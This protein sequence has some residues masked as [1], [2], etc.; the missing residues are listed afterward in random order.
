MGAPQSGDPNAPCFLRA[1]PNTH[2]LPS[3][4]LLA[5][6]DGPALGSS[7]HG[8]QGPYSAE[9]EELFVPCQCAAG[10]E[11]ALLELWQ[12]SQSAAVSALQMRKLAGAAG[13]EEWPGWLLPRA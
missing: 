6:Q 9:P 10:A 7:L 4:P 8:A 1:L 13:W 5:L 3:S 12:G 2:Q 11:L